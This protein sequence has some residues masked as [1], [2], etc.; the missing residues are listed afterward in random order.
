M[1]RHESP[2]SNLQGTSASRGLHDRASGR[3][4]LAGFHH[5][6]LGFALYL[7]P[8]PVLVARQWA[9]SLLQDNPARPTDVLAGRP[10]A[11]RP[12][13]GAIV[14]A[15]LSVGINGIAEAIHAGCDS[16]DAIGAATGAGTN[17]GSCRSEIQGIISSHRQAAE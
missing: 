3:H 8:E 4:S 16:V 14:C 1:G 12:D 10:G 15:C 11:D 17:C 6:K 13:A 9:T 2:A 7:S 5:G